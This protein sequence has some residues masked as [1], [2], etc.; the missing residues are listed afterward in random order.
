MYT[1]PSS[2]HL[3]AFHSLGQELPLCCR[4][5]VSHLIRVSVGQVCPVEDS[6]LETVCNNSK[7][8][9]KKKRIESIL[10]RSFCEAA[11]GNTVFMKSSSRVTNFVKVLVYMYTFELRCRSRGLTNL[12]AP[13]TD[14]CI[15]WVV[16]GSSSLKVLL[17]LVLTHHYVFFQ[18]SK[19]DR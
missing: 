6:V 14:R 4:W 16:I 5:R 18:E 15:S 2:L 17:L 1:L 19:Q 11:T 9:K 8:L 12:R 13:R 7:I 3:S 10:D